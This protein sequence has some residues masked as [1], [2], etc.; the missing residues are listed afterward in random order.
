MKIETRVDGDLSE[1]I[2]ALKDVAFDEFQSA[3]IH[4]QE[5]GNLHLYMVTDDGQEPEEPEATGSE[6]LPAKKKKKA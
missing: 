4:T 6:E 5:N 3:E 1:I 2:A